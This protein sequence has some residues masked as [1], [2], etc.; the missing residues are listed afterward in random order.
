[1]SLGSLGSLSMDEHLASL[2]LLWLVRDANKGWEDWG[3][4]AFVNRAWRD[5]FRTHKAQVVDY[6]LAH[7]Q[8]ML[9]EKNKQLR[10]F[11]MCCQ[12]SVAWPSLW[13]DDE[14]NGSSNDEAVAN[15][16]ATPPTSQEY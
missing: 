16:A 13:S 6:R 12:C 3:A 14:E 1:M 4:L 5:T 15:G 9:N 2:L 7:M 10:L 11:R 8:H